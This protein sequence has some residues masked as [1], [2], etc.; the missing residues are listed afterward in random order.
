MFFYL[1]YTYD[2]RGWIDNP[3]Y[4]RH[5]VATFKQHM[6]G[7]HT[8][9]ITHVYIL[10]SRLFSVIIPP[11]LH[12][13]CYYYDY[14][15]CTRTL[16]IDWLIR[17]HTMTAIRMTTGCKDLL[18]S[19]YTVLL[20]LPDGTTKTSNT[21]CSLIM[22]PPLFIPSQSRWL[23]CFIASPHCFIVIYSTV[24]LTA[25]KILRQA[26]TAIKK[27]SSRTKRQVVAG[28]HLKP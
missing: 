1:Y 9:T 13:Y 8:Y 24:E 7:C 15:Y 12:H 11:Q 6:A 5:S 21:S 4:R 14:W 23:F 3:L 25:A 19:Y 20:L 27:P 17:A 2:L 28:R 10:Y 22:P 18:L 16:H 26:K